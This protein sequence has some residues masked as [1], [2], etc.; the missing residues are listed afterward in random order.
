[1]QYS[2]DQRHCEYNGD[3]HSEPTLQGITGLWRGHAATL[4]H[5]MPYSAVNFAV[6]E[7]TR[8]VLTPVFRS[9]ADGGT[10]AAEVC[11]DACCILHVLGA[12]R[13]SQCSS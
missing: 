2:T 3:S 10:Y 11:F 6:F 8:K 1:M 12:S 9:P 4:L 13:Q 5:R 7:N